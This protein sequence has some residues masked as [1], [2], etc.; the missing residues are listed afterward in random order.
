[1]IY[2]EELFFDH[3]KRYAAKKEFS[4][5]V[6]KVVY[7]NSAEYKIMFF[8]MGEIQANPVVLFIRAD[9]VRF[10]S[11]EDE[12]RLKDMLDILFEQ[13]I[14]RERYFHLLVHSDYME[15]R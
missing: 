11:S 9:A 6:S 14:L 10:Y 12:P 3:I 8:S 15:E 2:G 13:T 1:M 4:Y 5:H 7:R